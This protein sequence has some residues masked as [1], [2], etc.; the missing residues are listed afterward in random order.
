MTETLSQN[1]PIK[2]ADALPSSWVDKTP[3][4]LEPYLRLSRYDRPV[5]FWLLAVPCWIAMAFTY[6]STPQDLNALVYAVLFGIGAIAMRGAGC[7]YNDLLDKDIDAKVERTAGRP[8]PSGRVSTRNAWIWL[9]L[10]CLVG[11]FVLLNLPRFAQYI[12]LGSIPLVAAYP[13][14]KR[15]TW[16]PQ[17]W[18]GLTFNWGALVAPATL[19]G[20]I[21]SADLVVYAALAFWTLGYDTIYALQ[22]K[23]D[24]ALIGVKSTARR[25]GG[26]VKG[27][28]TL[29]YSLCIVLLAVSCFLTQETG[30]LWGVALFAAHLGMQSFR[31]DPEASL[32][33]LHLFKSNR[34]A[35]LLL[36]I[37]WVG[38]ALLE[39][40]SDGRFGA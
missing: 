40:I 15:I 1:D 34:D 5:G 11:L 39:A 23:E 8:L 20:E 7:T 2:P 4:W 33:S 27:A 9:G 38:W 28:V 3:A 26:N 16:W 18:L 35:G 21:S 13:L 24:D 17:M 31:I 14:M 36:I 22:D 30:G 25:F 32:R 6:L 29:I 19:K 10:Q 12:A 37:A